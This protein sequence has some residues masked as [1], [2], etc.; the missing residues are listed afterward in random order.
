MVLYEQGVARGRFDLNR[1]VDMTSTNPAKT[2]GLYPRKGTIAPGSDADV[3][4]WD[5]QA[6]HT[7]SA[8]RHRSRA[9][10][11]LYEGMSVS[12]APRQVFSRGE[13]IVRDGELV[14][15][16]G[17]GRYQSRTSLSER[18]PI[19]LPANRSESFR[20]IDCEV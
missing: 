5:P 9:G 13:Q 17:H 3:V 15:M 1:F 19:P 10:Y 18:A 16:Y 2:F 8:D 14:E 20:P 7:I 4:I 6:E 12:G 11:T